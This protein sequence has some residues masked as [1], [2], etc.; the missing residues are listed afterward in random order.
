MIGAKR[1]GVKTRQTEENLSLLVMTSNWTSG[2][3]RELRGYPR[4]DKAILAACCRHTLQTI[5]L[6]PSN[7]RSLLRE[8]QIFKK[9]LLEKIKIL[10]PEMGNLDQNY[11]AF[12]DT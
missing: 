3:P 4:P 10:V 9:R 12:F 1:F 11:G 7:F 6:I 5:E 8:P 2:R